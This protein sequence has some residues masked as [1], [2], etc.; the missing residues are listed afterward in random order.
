M[1]PPGDGAKRQARGKGS[2]TCGEEGRRRSCQ[3]SRGVDLLR[4]KYVITFNRALRLHPSAGRKEGCRGKALQKERSAAP[5]QKGSKRKCG[6]R[7]EQKS[8]M[9]TPDAR[10]VRPHGDAAGPAPEGGFATAKH[11]LA[12]G[13]IGLCEVHTAKLN[14]SGNGTRTETKLNRD[15]NGTKQKLPGGGLQQLHPAAARP[16][17][18]M[19][20][21]AND[22]APFN[23]LPSERCYGS[24]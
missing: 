5:T 19:I 7:G 10:C 18:R 2:K 13:F 16:A 1:P 22:V 11:N 8:G 23:P 12:E 20:C 17:H 21:A 14:Q 4:I 24:L 9:N 6:P 15:G 3:K